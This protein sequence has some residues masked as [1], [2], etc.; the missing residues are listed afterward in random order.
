[1]KKN[2]FISNELI[3]HFKRLF[4]NILPRSRGSTPEDIAFLQGQQSVIDRM[5]MIYEDDQP[6]ES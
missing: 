6:D 2:I 3:E 1:M 4:P 5:V